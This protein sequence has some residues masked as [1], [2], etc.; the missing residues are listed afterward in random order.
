MNESSNQISNSLVCSLKY[1]YEL[2][3]PLLKVMRRFSTSNQMFVS[4]R[5]SFNTRIVIILSTSSGIKG[6]GQRG[7][8]LSLSILR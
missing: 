2:S 3:S 8:G 6:K 5:N 7:N 1:K 4:L